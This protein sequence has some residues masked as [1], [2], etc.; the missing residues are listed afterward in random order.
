MTIKEIIDNTIK[1]DSD[2]SGIKVAIQNKNE[3]TFF[4]NPTEIFF[5][6]LSDV[7]VE[8]LDLEVVERSQIC[9]SSNESRNG[10][11]VLIVQLN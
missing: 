1:S 6:E 4:D 7:P 3:L 5:G 10:A 11:N 8:Y 9:A 2:I